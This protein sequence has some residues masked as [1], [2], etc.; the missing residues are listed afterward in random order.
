MGRAAIWLAMGGAIAVSCAWWHPLELIDAAMVGNMG[1]AQME[2]LAQLTSAW[3]VIAGTGLAVFV[4]LYPE[5]SST[6]QKMGA[7]KD[8]LR[9]DRMM[10]EQEAQAMEEAAVL[11]R[12]VASEKAFSVGRPSRRL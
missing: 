7:R 3:T 10:A 4:A 12:L 8:S 5:G 2:A 11:A 1:V 6:I 9:V